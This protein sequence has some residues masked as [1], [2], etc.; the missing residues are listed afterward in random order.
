MLT[1]WNAGAAA[2]KLFPAELTPARGG[3]RA[4]R[5]PLG[6]V[7]FIP[8]GGVTAENAG[9][10]LAAGAQA[11]AVGGWLVGD[12]R[13]AGVRARAQAL[14]AQVEHAAVAR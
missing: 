4:L 5:G 1:A 3:L 2:V 6:H 14:R 10:F 12:G 13:P 11:V 9:D 7:P 8:T